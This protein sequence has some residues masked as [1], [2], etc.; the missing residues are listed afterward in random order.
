MSTIVKETNTICS[1][2]WDGS[3]PNK[4]KL[5]YVPKHININRGYIILTS[6]FDS[7]YPKGIE[8]GIVDS[9]NKNVNSNFYEIDITLSQDFYNL[10][11]V[12]IIKEELSDEKLSLEKITNDEK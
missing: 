3:N 8:V 7:I 12:Y 9:V 2:N 1:I 4:V 10:S 11:S 5:L 6:S